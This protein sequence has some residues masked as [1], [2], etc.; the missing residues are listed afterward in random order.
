MPTKAVRTKNKKY[1]VEKR[2]EISTKACVIG[3]AL[4]LLVLLCVIY[5]HIKKYNS[6]SNSPIISLTA[7]ADRNSAEVTTG[8]HGKTGVLFCI[9]SHEYYIRT[10]GD[11]VTENYDAWELAGKINE[12]AELQIE[13]VE[14][15]YGVFHDFTRYE[16]TMLSVEGR[17]ISETDKTLPAILRTHKSYITVFALISGFVGLLLIIFVLFLI[18]ESKKNKRTKQ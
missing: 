5:N 16:V 18:D 15:K 9:N 14:E 12:G 13:C 7:A 10:D 4:V 17:R 3:C 1:R 2:K 11:F 8:R 6:V